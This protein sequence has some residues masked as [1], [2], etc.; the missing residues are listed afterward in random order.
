[1]SVSDRARGIRSEPTEVPFGLSITQNGHTYGLS[2][3]RLPPSPLRTQM[4]D[5]CLSFA[6]DRGG[7][8]KSA[9]SMSNQVEHAISMGRAIAAVVPNA[10]LDAA[11]LRVEDVHRAAFLSI[12]KPASQ[13]LVVGRKVLKRAAELAGNAALTVYLTNIRLYGYTARG[14]G[15]KPYTEVELTT[16]LDYAKQA[17]H[18]L[19]KQQTAALGRLGLAANATDQEAVAAATAVLAGTKHSFALPSDAPEAG[20]DWGDV[21]SNARWWTAQ[22]LVNGFSLVPGEHHQQRRYFLEAQDAWFPTVDEAHAAVLLIINEFG[23][24]GQV[25]AGL[26]AGETRRVGGEFSSV[27]EVSGVKS[28]ASKAVSRRGNALSHWSGGRVLERWERHTAPARRWTGVNLLWQFRLRATYGGGPRMLRVPISNFLPGPGLLNGQAR[29]RYVDLPDGGTVAFSPQ[30][31]RKTWAVRSER[32][33]GSMIAGAIDPMHS[34][35]VSW[36]F[37]RSV[38]YNGQER[39]ELLSEAQDDLMAMVKAVQVVADLA[40][41]RD[42]TAALRKQGVSEDV[43]QRLV[44]EGLDDSGTSLCSNMREAPGQAIGTICKQTPFACLLCKNAIHTRVHLPVLLA[45]QESLAAERQS[46][47]A[48]QYVAAWAGVDAALGNIL[49][50]FSASALFAA[51]TD[52]MQARAQLQKLKDAFT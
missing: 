34:A 43:I 22:V 38:A 23:I 2:L 41:G 12:P 9:I 5:A 1:M 40:P 35:K 4:R 16:L 45:L 7:T 21:P 24:E 18:N 33:L 44:R 14:G 11:E 28:R 10:Q 47:P 13:K 50:R 46:M 30:R 17:L 31:M 36:A 20:A 26:R 8:L 48:E 52:L 32:A 15:S 39:R 29:I 49:S 3:E 51:R 6:A 37:Y 27:L 42:V 19:E 25:L